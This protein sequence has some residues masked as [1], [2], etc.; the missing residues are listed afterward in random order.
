MR[1]GSFHEFEGIV[2]SMLKITSLD[3]FCHFVCRKRN[4]KA[5]LIISSWR[6]FLSSS[7]GK[8]GTNNW[9]IWL[10]MKRFLIFGLLIESNACELEREWPY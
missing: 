2:N 10:F 3:Y 9:T 1:G 6:W 4:G 8:P 7:N 5:E